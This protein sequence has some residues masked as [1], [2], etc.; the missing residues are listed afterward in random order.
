MVFQYIMMR[1][2]KLKLTIQLNIIHHKT[3]R[4]IHSFSIYK[5]TIKYNFLTTTKRGKLRNKY[6]SL[7]HAI[8]SISYIIHS[9]IFISL[10]LIAI[11]SVKL[12]R[13]L[14]INVLH[15]KFINL[16]GDKW[17]FLCVN[18]KSVA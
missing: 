2:W 4:F 3:I 10:H 9:I 18:S 12:L 15:D 16:H 13:I 7:S 14:M 11:Y 17:H 6:Y 1:T 8:T 5:Y